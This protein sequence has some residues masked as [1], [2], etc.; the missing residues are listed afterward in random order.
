MHLVAVELAVR[1]GE[2]DELEDAQ[3][4]IEALGGEDELRTHLLAVDDHHLACLELTDERG[5]DHVEGGGLRGQDPAL[6]ELVGGLQASQAQWTEPVGVPD[7]DQ[8]VGIE[9]D[10]GERPAHLGKHGAEGGHQVTLAF[11]LGREGLGQELGHQVAVRGDHPGKHA[12]GLGEGGGVGQVAV[13]GQTEPGPPD[14]PVHGLGVPPRPRARRRVPGVADTQ[15]PTE[16]G[17]LPLVEHGGDQAHVLHHGDGVAIAEGH[18]GRFL[19]PMLQGVQ[20]IEDQVCDRAP[21]GV[22]PEDTTRFLGLHH[23]F[24]TVVTGGRRAR[25]SRAARSERLPSPAD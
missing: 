25:R 16:A 17:E 10:E 4:G 5:P 11:R 3:T 23:R 13:M 24:V 21:R 7:P 15:V 14:A 6:L 8:P 2:V 12:G 22:D 9:E 19:A 18:S 20:T 1:P